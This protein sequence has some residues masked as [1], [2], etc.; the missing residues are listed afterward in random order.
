MKQRFAFRKYFPAIFGIAFFTGSISVSPAAPNYPGLFKSTSSQRL[1][2]TARDHNWSIN[3]DK[4]V[5]V[6]TLHIVAVR[7]EFNNGEKD[8][9]KLTTGDGTFGIRK[10]GDIDEVRRYKDDTTYRYD[11]LPHDSA[12]FSHQLETA[13]KYFTKVSHGKLVLQYSIFPADPG[14]QGYYVKQPMTYYSPG[15][16]K[17]AETY[18]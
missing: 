7:I 8:T 4:R 5:P 18:D 9:S 12:Y 16:K 1:V 10:M 14:E 3:F 17:K 6:D 13:C 11:R 15:V 2:E